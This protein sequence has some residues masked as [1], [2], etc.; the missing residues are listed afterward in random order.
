MSC[1]KVGRLSGRSVSPRVTEERLRQI[2]PRLPVTRIVDLT[3]LDPIRLPVFSAVTP[4]ALDLTSHQGKGVDAVSARVSAMMEAVERISAE[5]PPPGLTCKA[6]FEQ[7]TDQRRQLAADPEWFC[8]PSDTAYT[9]AAVMTWVEGFDLLRRAPVLLPL[10]LAISPPREGILQEVDTNGL[11]S[12]NTRLEAVI[13]ALCEV[14]ERDVL[15]QHTFTALFADHRDR[16]VPKHAVDL[17]TLPET[18]A[19]WIETI[20]SAGHDVMIDDLTGDLEVAT[21]R[22]LIIDDRFPDPQGAMTVSFLGFGTHPD[23]ETAVQRSITEAV[24]SRLA[25]ILGARDSFN[26]FPRTRRRTSL[27]ILLAERQPDRV[28]PFSETPSF[29]DVDLLED[30]RFLLKRLERRGYDRVI[31][32]DLTRADLG[33][34]VVRVRVPG[35]SGFLVN[36]RRIDWRCLRHLL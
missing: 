15:S 11:A 14:I 23:A 5:D 25:Y 3:P 18:S 7:L 30:L 6:S 26:H 21:F 22:T 13:H 36:R 2:L 9:R 34:P 33:I 8:L 24:Q 28:R 20:R 1:R 17:A 12:G 19:A 29:F 35:L 10:D 4:L 27:D 31:A 16:A 32:V